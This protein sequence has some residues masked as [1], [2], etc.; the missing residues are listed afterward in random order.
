VT[1]LRS[2]S[3]T[4]VGQ[5]RSNNQDSLLVLASADLYGVADGMGGHNGGEVAS[6]MAVENLEEH[7]GE[8][9]LENLKQAARIGNRAIFEKAGADPDL[10]GMGT[11]LCAVRVVPGPEGDEIAWINVGDSRV[12]L[13]RDNELIQLSR[14]HSLVEDLLRDG[15]LTP[16]EAKVHP[17]RNI[18]TRAL[19][20]DVDVDVDGSTVIPFNGDR[21][22]LC[23]DG[24]FGEVTADQISSVLRRLADPTEAA[25]ELVRL[26]NESGG[27]DN[28]TVVI[29]E[30][31]DDDGRSLAAAAALAAEESRLQ[32]HGADQTAVVEGEPDTEPVADAEPYVPVFADRKSSLP[33]AGDHF[34]ADDDE[35]DPFGALDGPHP[36]RFT[37]RVAL[38]VVALLAVIGVVLG[39]IVWTGNN[40]YHVGFNGENVAVYQGKAGGVLWIEPKLVETTDITRSELPEDARAAVA[41]NKEFG[42]EG[43]ATRYIVTL[44]AIVDDQAAATTTTTTATTTTTTAVATSTAPPVT[45]T[46]A[47]AAPT[48]VP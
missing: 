14:D 36:S 31:V 21:F 38:F 16:D 33:E 19:G 1:T 48:T 35:D 13:F 9:T 18:I 4:H 10:H 42:S 27:R 6:A 23:S 43:A 45:T 20:I 26:A 2:G 15:Q 29:V 12:Y 5:V 3:S 44:Q 24:L 40:T 7:A 46:T 32:S 30:V 11:T 8:A 41:A 34:G 47:P 39:A 25:D 22:L 37:W 28:I 17:K